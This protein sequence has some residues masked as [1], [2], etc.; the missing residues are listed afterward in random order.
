VDGRYPRRPYRQALVEE[1]GGMPTTYLRIDL[2]DGAI[3]EVFREDICGSHHIQPCPARQNLW[4]IDRD[5]PPDFWAGGDG[6]RSTRAWLLDTDN[7]EM[8]CLKQNDLWGF[9]IHTN[10]NPRG[11]RIY[12]HGPSAQGG[13]YIGVY[14]Y[15]RARD[16]GTC[17]RRA[18]LRPCER[19]YPG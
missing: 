9:Q 1:F 18:V 16:L 12:Y 17:L 10:W 2:A 6:R 13:Q 5:M 19:A 11:D 4:L 15:T 7:S 8:V 14:R 3:H